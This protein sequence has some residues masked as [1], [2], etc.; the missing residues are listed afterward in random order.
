VVEVKEAYEFSQDGTSRSEWGSLRD[1][2]SFYIQQEIQKFCVDFCGCAYAA[3]VFERCMIWRV[4]GA[5]TYVAFTA[6]LCFVNNR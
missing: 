2:S 4:F 6:K 5:D 1:V 3:L